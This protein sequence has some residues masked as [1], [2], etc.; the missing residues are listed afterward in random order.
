LLHGKTD[1]GVDNAIWKLEASKVPELAQYL[2]DKAIYIV[3]GHHRY[4][5]ALNYAREIGALGK[6]GHPASRMLFSLA[7]AYDPGL[8]VM[9]THR[10][11]HGVEHVNADLIHKRYDLVPMTPDELKSF[12][13]KPR[14]TPDF[15]LYWQGKLY[16]CTPKHWERQEQNLGH[17]IYKLAVHWSDHIFLPS[18]AGVDDTNRKEKVTYER[19]WAKAWENRDRADLVIFHAPPAITDVMDVADERKF[20]PQKST[21]FFPKLAAGLIM[22]GH[23]SSH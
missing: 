4:E 8:V 18:V 21:Y 19:E 10:V 23:T 5:S 11:V 14:K 6:E 17:S 1:D 3:D 7:N 9:P 22:R 16:R 2:E 13:A 20:M 12:V 15:G